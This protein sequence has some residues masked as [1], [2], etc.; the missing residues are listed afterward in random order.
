[1]NSEILNAVDQASRWMQ[2]DGVEGVGQ[3][4][5]DGRACITVLVSCPPSEL[6]AKIPDTFEG[7]PVVFKET[8]VISAQ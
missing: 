4:Q 8:G 1:M 3:G 7:F 5:K 6:A 2:F